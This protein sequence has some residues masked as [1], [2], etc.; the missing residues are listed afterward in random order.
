MSPRLELRLEGEILR[1]YEPTTCR[2]LLSYEES[3]QARQA[4]EAQLERERAAR[5]AIEARLAELEA[6]SSTTVVLQ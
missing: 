2:R 1:F 4:A 5:H 3:E 6:R